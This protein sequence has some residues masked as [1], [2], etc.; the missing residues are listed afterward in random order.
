MEIVF[1]NTV[2]YGMGLCGSLLLMALLP[3][4]HIALKYTCPL[5]FEVGKLP[6][7]LRLGNLLSR[8]LKHLAYRCIATRSGILKSWSVG[9]SLLVAAY[10]A[11]NLTCIFI[12]LPTTEKAGARAGTLALINMLILYLGPCLSFIADVLHISLRAHR[13][14]HAYA[15][16]IV[17]MLTIFHTIVAVI[18][19]GSFSLKETRNIW[20]F[21]VCILKV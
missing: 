7:L 12:D 3:Y 5:I 9:N 6:P 10:L 13:R 16:R 11:A 21:V 1:D 8:G 20:P 15:G 17:L 14:I 2:A 4:T 18:R 19:Q